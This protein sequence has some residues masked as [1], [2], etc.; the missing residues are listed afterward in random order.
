ME[1]DNLIFIQFEFVEGNKD[2]LII[3]YRDI[4]QT[5]NNL[6][7][8]KLGNILDD[9]VLLSHSI[10]LIQGVKIIQ[11]K[12]YNYY[13]STSS[14]TKYVVDVY[15]LDET[16]INGPI[17]SH[18][19]Y[20][21]D[22]ES[23]ENEIIMPQNYQITSAFANAIT[24]DNN[25]ATPSFYMVAKNDSIV[26]NNKYNYFLFQYDINYGVGRNLDFSEYSQIESSNIAP[27][28]V[29]EPDLLQTEES[30]IDNMLTDNLFEIRVI[31]QNT[32]LIVYTKEKSL[33]IK[34]YDDYEFL[35]QEIGSFSEKVIN[36]DLN[37]NNSNQVITV[38][39]ENKYHIY[40]FEYHGS[41]EIQDIYHK[42][43]EKYENKN[44]ISNI[45]NL[46]EFIIFGYYSSSN[47]I[48]IILKY[49]N[50]NEEK[51]LELN[52][53]F[54]LK[55]IFYHEDILY[56]YSEQNSYYQFDISEEK[57]VSKYLLNLISEK[58]IIII[59]D[60]KYYFSNIY[61]S[62][63]LV[64]NHRSILNL[65]VPDIQIFDFRVINN[66]YIKLV[67]CSSIN[68]NKNIILYNLETGDI[69]NN[70]FNF[71]FS[72]FQG[73]NLLLFDTREHNKKITVRYLNLE[74]EILYLNQFESEGY[75]Y[76]NIGFLKKD[77]ERID[78]WGI[79]IDREDIE[80]SYVINKL[81][82]QNVSKGKY[83]TYSYESISDLD[84]VNIDDENQNILMKIDTELG[85]SHVSKNTTP[86]TNLVLEL[87][88]DVKIVEVDNSYK[89]LFEHKQIGGSG[90]GS[91][92]S[93]NDYRL[94]EGTY[95]LKNIPYKYP[96]AIFGQNSYR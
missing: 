14:P 94:K 82:Y 17:S 93:N 73:G 65:E 25:S 86:E 43:F 84:T 29:V 74:L 33:F 57:L 37:S 5:S 30:I 8:L 78:F 52:T 91:F 51:L 53:S 85:N 19:I 10:P 42:T 79:Q 9:F 56:I 16:D 11:D 88:T 69:K 6:L 50:G 45:L 66:T 64:K 47:D 89:Y 1:K 15:D 67:Y 34:I 49:E 35:E 27:I 54:N 36:L 58:N 68:R 77:N 22:D 46:E 81:K 13:Y 21:V 2:Y 71:K 62:Y 76:S 61:K 4:T 7:V 92:N 83:P 26:N 59:D 90:F 96:L 3:V 20:N 75:E 63:H 28:E 80:E 32:I 48:F 18:E 12:L 44:S 70:N 40:Q 60:D 31:L 23:I 39:T 55:F 87:V 38:E 41:G 95:I 24:V 72:T